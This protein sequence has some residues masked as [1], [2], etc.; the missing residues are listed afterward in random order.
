M[1]VARAKEVEQHLQLAAYGNEVAEEATSRR[2]GSFAVKGR[3]VTTSIMRRCKGGMAMVALL[4]P[5]SAHP[6]STP[7]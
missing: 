5:Q 7:A 1:R 4:T 6:T 2:E 3:H